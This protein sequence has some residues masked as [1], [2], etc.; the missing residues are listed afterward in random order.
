MREVTETSNTNILFVQ[1]QPTSPIDTSNYI[2]V[3]FKRQSIEEQIGKKLER[4]SIGRWLAGDLSASGANMLFQVNDFEKSLKIALDVLE[5]NGIRG[6]TVV[7]RRVL[8]SDGNWTYRIVF[9]NSN[10]RKFNKL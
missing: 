8:D 1:W 9:P 3:I 6:E 10:L 4:N 5:S 2:D 7:A